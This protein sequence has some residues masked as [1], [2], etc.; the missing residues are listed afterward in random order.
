M[1]YFLEPRLPSDAPLR[2]IVIGR[3]W[4]SQRRKLG[5]S[6]MKKLSTLWII[7]VLVSCGT[8][9]V[10]ADDLPFDPNIALSPGTGV[11]NGP[12]ITSD[13]FTFIDNS[14]SPMV[15]LQGANH[16]WSNLLITTDQNPAGQL[17]SY[18]CTPSDYFTDCSVT[19]TGNMV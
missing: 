6:C 8:T 3:R 10:F 19:L 1:C 4:W 16:T 9:L 7:L 17:S 15:F 11:G 2:S 14:N 12:T 13:S 5:D 18:N